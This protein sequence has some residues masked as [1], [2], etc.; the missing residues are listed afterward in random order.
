MGL[1]TATGATEANMHQIA[2]FR[3]SPIDDRIGFDSPQRR[4]ETSGNSLFRTFQCL[5]FG[6]DPPKGLHPQNPI[7]QSQASDV[8]VIILA[9]GERSTRA[10]RENIDVTCLVHEVFE[11]CERNRLTLVR[12][13]GFIDWNANGVRV[14]GI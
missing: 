3:Q 7:A 9:I 10:L 8:L 13:Q 14:L 12:A 6:T 11:N 5:F 1:D 4:Q 2:L